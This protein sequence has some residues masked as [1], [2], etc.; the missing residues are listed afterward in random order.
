MSFWEELRTLFYQK[1]PTIGPAPNLPALQYSLRMVDED[2][3]EVQRFNNGW[4]RLWFWFC[5]F[6]MMFFVVMSW[7]DQDNLW[8]NIQIWLNSEAYFRGTLER[9][10]MRSPEV[11]GTEDF[12]EFYARMMDLHGG[13]WIKGAIYLALPTFFFIAACIWPRH[14]PIRFNRTL[15]IAYTWSWG[16]FFLSRADKSLGLGRGMGDFELMLAP[17]GAPQGA[18]HSPT[19]CVG[20]LILRLRHHRWTRYKESWALGVFPAACRHQNSEVSIAINDFLTNPKRPEWCD[21]LA[22]QPSLLSWPHR[23][24]MLVVNFTVL[25][26]WWPRRTEKMLQRHREQRA[27]EEATAAQAREA[28]RRKAN[29]MD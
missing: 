15:G 20:A 5:F 25:P 27:E 6:L 14:R 11:Y 26:A 28:L 23:L 8:G 10:T 4:Y 2:T 1:A 13:R 24:A 7:R 9:L 3:L 22:N 17:V 21:A 16:R 18:G 19:H 12:G 29:G